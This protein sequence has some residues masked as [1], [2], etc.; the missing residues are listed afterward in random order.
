M[1]SVLAVELFSIILAF[2]AA[3]IVKS[4]LDLF[5]EALTKS[6]R[7]KVSNSI[8]SVDSTYKIPLILATN[9]KSLHDYLI[10]LVTTTKKRLIVDIILLR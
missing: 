7:A 8:T 10:K 6:K 4:T 1:R 9:S 5:V 3:T 2:N